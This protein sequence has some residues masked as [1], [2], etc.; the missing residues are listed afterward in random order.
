MSYHHYK[1]I[2]F[3]KAIFIFLFILPVKIYSQVPLE[4]RTSHQQPFRFDANAR[5]GTPLVV[6]ELL[7]L[8]AEGSG[9]LR[10]FT[11]YDITAQVSVGV[12]AGDNQQLQFWIEVGE[13]N[14]QGDLH[15]RGISIEQFLLPPYLE[16]TL[17][18]LGTNDR[19]LGEVKLENVL[20]QGKTPGDV[21]HS[22]SLLN[23][24]GREQISIE[25]KKIAFGYPGD[26]V[27]T[28][29]ELQATFSSYYKARA[30]IEEVD[31][32]VERLKPFAFETAILDEFALCE[33]EVLMA[34]LIR[35]PFHDLVTEQNDPENI[36]PLFTALQNKIARYRLDF[37]HVISH[38]DS[39]YYMKGKQLLLSDWDK[40]RDY[41]E[42]AVNFNPLHFPSHIELGKMDVSARKPVL[43]LQRFQ[44]LLSVIHP[45]EIFKEET[46]E[47]VSWLYEGESERASEAMKDGRFLDALHILG[48]V[49]KFCTSLIA[50]DCP[51]DLYAQIREVHYGMYRS[52]LSVAARAY[53][54]ANYPFS[55]NYIKSALDYKEKNSTYITTDGEA[56]ELLQK[57]LD[58]YYK[59][60]D[61]AFLMNN[62]QSAANHLQ[63]AE[64]LC[65]SY[66][67]LRPRANATALAIRVTQLLQQQ[68][69]NKPDLQINLPQPVK[70]GP[71]ILT[72]EN[73][74]DQVKELLS[75]GHLKA[76]AGEVEEAKTILAE[77]LPLV[78][79][80]ELRNDYEISSRI[81]SL[82]EMI[83]TRECELTYSSM[84]NLLDVATDYF[85]RGYLAEAG[86][87]YVMASQLNENTVHCTWDMGDTLKMLQYIEVAGQ[88]QSLV[89]AAQSAYYNAGSGGFEPFITK[90]REAGRFYT[91]NQ[92]H[93]YG[94]KHTSLSDFAASTA[95]T[96]LIKLAVTELSDHGFPDE[97]LGL[98]K[99]LKKQGF[100]ARQ[101]R[102]LQ[103]HAGSKAAQHIHASHPGTKPNG[104]LA[105][106][107]ANDPWF[108]N[109]SRSF[110]R[111]WP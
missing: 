49:E 61:E 32:K 89:H 86:N 28:A 93:N 62:F 41:F 20:W 65:E 40:A 87:N 69:Y 6:N 52:Y 56:M 44:K 76:W 92:L 97:A 66:P 71:F 42:K 73:A 36:L 29:V 77:I 94:V 84:R 70:S 72:V 14:L 7:Q 83:A 91:D 48:E 106:K 16:V 96:S 82:T 23:G 74:S 19:P 107:T 27:D 35:E 3:Y 8:I 22:Y 105:E 11:G 90:Y 79:K 43:A 68:A 15:Y 51:T 88:Y 50:Y 2:A 1:W 80:Y 108:K 95:N 18:V 78:A 37:N 57:V 58:G 98:L 60:T 101:L 102:T 38:I 104:Y 99:I 24:R 46:F 21:V 109:Y 31:Q 103:E 34:G 63:A 85:K 81:T 75:K 26:Y 54:S 5:Q 47:F 55:V 39:L 33:A 13:V 67:T 30:Q 110:I 59:L 17:N 10:A 53:T 111:N 9:K 100:D 45:P 12:K 64:G 4:V 25:I